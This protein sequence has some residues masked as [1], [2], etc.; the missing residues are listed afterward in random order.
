MAGCVSLGK[1]RC[2]LKSKH[3]AKFIIAILVC[4]TN[5]AVFA[6]GGTRSFLLS[7]DEALLA[8]PSTTFS[9]ELA[10][11]KLDAPRFHANPPTNGYA[12]QSTEADL[13]DL[14]SALRRSGMPAA[15]SQLVLEDYESARLK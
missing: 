3:Y 2:Q 11:M 6:H 8:P 12:A 15:E 4:F 9:L 10:R 14:R 13:A 1:Q 7:G 5:G